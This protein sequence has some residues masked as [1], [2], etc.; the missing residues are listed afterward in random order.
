MCTMPRVTG[1]E[2]RLHVEKNCFFSLSE[3]VSSAK[4]RSHTAG[5]LRSA[6]CVLRL[7]QEERLP[8]R[9]LAQE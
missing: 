6:R 1:C 2:P 5:S 3:S 4:T 8:S 9:R 7:W